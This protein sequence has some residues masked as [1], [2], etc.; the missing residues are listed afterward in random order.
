[1]ALTDTDSIKRRETAQCLDSLLLSE[2]IDMWSYNGRVYILP[3]ENRGQDVG[4]FCGHDR[5]FEAKV[6]FKAFPEA[7]GA[8]YHQIDV[9]GYSLTEM[10]APE[11][12]VIYLPLQ[13]TSMRSTK[14]MSDGARK[15][16]ISPRGG[17]FPFKV[18]G[19]RGSQGLL[20]LMIMGESDSGPQYGV[21]YMD[22]EDSL[23]LSDVN[24]LD[25][26]QKIDIYDI[27]QAFWRSEHTAA[28][29]P[30]VSTTKTV[31]SVPA[32]TRRSSH[33]TTTA[34][35]VNIYDPQNL[36]EHLDRFV[37]GQETLKKRLA[38]AAMVYALKVRDK[39]DD[40]EHKHVLI[41]GSTGTGKTYTA[42]IVAKLLAEALGIPYALYTG[43]GKS[44]TG[45]VGDNLAQMFRTI[46]KNS[47]PQD[48][49][50]YGVM[51]IDEVDKLARVN[52]SQFKQDL[53]DEMIGWLGGTP[54]L[55]ENGGRSDLPEMNT[56]NLLFITAGAFQD[57]E[58]GE[59]LFDIIRERVGGGK[60]RIGFGATS[61]EITTL[62]DGQ[63]I[64]QVT[65]A[66]IIAYGLKPEL[67]G[68]LSSLVHAHPLT[69][70]QLERIVASAERSV[71]SNHQRVLY[72][73]GYKLFWQDDVPAA[74]VSHTPPGTGARA[75]K[76]VCDRIFD[77]I[78]YR[79]KHYCNG[80]KVIR[81][82]AE[83]IERLL[84]PADIQ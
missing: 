76:G 78:E 79:P 67:V 84:K 82:D 33:R 9:I 7:Y 34:S 19:V 45:Y 48:I 16:G 68:R 41:A 66:D 31:K 55:G 42:E 75:L 26:E 65:P 23:W 63:L 70:D 1:M 61:E 49:A 20:P 62:T 10:V 22:G 38:V 24:F 25:Y 64:S 11:K 18:M 83:L 81:L 27:V 30:E 36:V 69:Q 73:Q 17:R 40:L 46:R 35:K 3:I 43:T 52:A 53:Q 14:G 13:S 54:V 59:P 5:N 15:A 29:E 74:I 6:G 12:E 80:E 21:F 72:K 57:T 51:V 28:T 50:P 44:A 71:L 2:E 60:K 58:K 56:R 37:V 4:Y 39:D 32:V 8:T 77:D 47:D